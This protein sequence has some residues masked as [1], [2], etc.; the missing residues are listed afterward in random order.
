V[1]GTVLDGY[2]NQK[3]VELLRGTGR[4]I[5]LKL[6]RHKAGSTYEQLVLAASQCKLSD[7]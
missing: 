4:V 1:D 7:D 2:S 5:H 3:A 6:A